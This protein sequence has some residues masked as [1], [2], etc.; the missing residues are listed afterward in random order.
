ML[1]ICEIVGETVG[2]Q[3]KTCSH[4]DPVLSLVL[5]CEVSTLYSSMG[6][7]PE[8]WRWVLRKSVFTLVLS[9]ESYPGTVPG[10]QVRTLP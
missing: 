5:K 10:H 1:A 7:E 8:F 9:L 2:N 4:K 3:R 6:S